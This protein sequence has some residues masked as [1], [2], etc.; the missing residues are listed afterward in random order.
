MWNDNCG[1][2][3]SEAAV[4][5]PLSRFLNRGCHAIS[6][7]FSDFPITSTEGRTSRPYYDLKEGENTDTGNLSRGLPGLCSVRLFWKGIP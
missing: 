5:I 3:I 7:F 2:G 6:L 1:W 4:E